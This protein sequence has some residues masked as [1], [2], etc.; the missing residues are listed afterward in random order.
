MQR[1]ILGRIAQ[2]ILCLFA[3]GTIVFIM[4]RMS[5]DP[6]VMMMP[7]DATL[8]EIQAMRVRLGLDKPYIVQYVLF[9]TSMLHGD[10]GRSI[11]YEQSAM[12]LVMER[13]PATLELSVVAMAIA[14]LI[15]LPVGIMAAVKKDTAFDSFGKIFALSGQSMPVF[16]V[17]IMLMWLFAVV[18]KIL[19]PF[20]RGGFENLILPS[21]TLGWFVNATL[22]R[23]GRSSMLDVL[24]SEYIKLARVKG[25]PE[26][27]VILKHALRNAG[28]PIL[29]IVGMQFAQILRGAIVTETVF[30][31]PG[32]G[33]LAVAAIYARDFPLVQASVIFMAFIFIG[34]NL[35]VD[36]LY[37]YVDPRIKYQG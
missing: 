31:W 11:R 29:T 20:G 16:W 7:K 4:S 30:A 36:I 24:D 3:V 17:G 18:L 37:A 35:I 22:M 2:A 8:E 5:G 12:G 32:L 27:M 15:A 23:V 13:F 19:P 25:V 21:V 14:I 34:M 6:L 1:Y 26:R 9:I 28:I 10:F 33:R